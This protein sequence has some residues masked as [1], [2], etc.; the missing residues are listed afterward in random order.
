[1]PPIRV[2]VVEDFAPFRRFLC[3]T[4]AKMPALQVICEVADG[5]E[6]VQKAQELTPDL[7]LLD[8]GLPTL[9]G[10][11]AA[12]QIRNLAPASKIIFV[13]QESSAEV[14]QEAL[15]TGA[16]GYVVKTTANGNLLA[17]VEAVLEGRQFVGGVPPSSGSL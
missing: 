12:R 1:M 15:R 2:L 8:I 16:L 3:S 13:T 5:Q 10:I 7:I 11:A 17:A 6:A 9:N 4:L 14:V